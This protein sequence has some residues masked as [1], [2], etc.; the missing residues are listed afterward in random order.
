MISRP[1]ADAAERGRPLLG[2]W[3]IVFAGSGNAGLVGVV[4]VVGGVRVKEGNFGVVN[5]A[6]ERDLLWR[7][8][9]LVFVPQ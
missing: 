8:W 3:I 1:S 9:W 6:F 4:E 5:E 2:M 7:R